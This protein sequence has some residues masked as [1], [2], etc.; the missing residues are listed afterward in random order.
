MNVTDSNKTEI[1]QNNIQ[2]R[3][4]RPS[5]FRSMIFRFV[6][7]LLLLVLCQIPVSMIDSY[8][9]DQSLNKLSAIKE[10]SNKWGNKQTIIGPILSIPYVERISRIESQTDSNGLKSS[11]SRDIFNNK[12]L[13]LLPE[14]L[15]ITADLKEKILTQDEN[16][17]HVYQGNIELTGNFD[18]DALPEASGYNTIEWDKA[19]VAIGLNEN[20]SIEASSP[21]RWEGSSTAFKPGTQLPHLIKQGFHASL[22]NVSTDNKTPQFKIQ[23][24]LKGKDSFQFAPF[25]EL[26]TANITSNIATIKPFGDISESSKVIS[27]NEFDAT[28]RISNLSRNYPQQWLI[29]EKQTEKANYNFSSVLTGVEFTDP[30]SIKDQ[31]IE[32]LDKVT[33]YIIPLLAVLFLCLFT[34]EFRHRKT[35]KPT[36]LHYIIVS[37]PLLL[38]PIILIALLEIISFVQA[39]QIAAGSSI[40]LIVLFLL[41]SLKSFGRAFLVLL[42][43]GTLFATL[44]ITIEMPEY[45]I[46]ALS[47]SGIFITILLMMSSTNLKEQS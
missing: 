25:G 31:N 4:P 10:M 20:K 46:M 19:F 7:L 15:R 30:S 5:F 13:M 47:A 34:L 2:K 3:H 37:L 16:N 29:D 44:F 27:D 38:M 24:S 18:L 1:L 21:L 28:W 17:A 35:N 8:V 40:V 6:A 42:I 32:N 26:T 39:Y 45:S 36:F 23:L 14:N 12:T 41:S 43:L 33:A 9:S 22:E 11:I